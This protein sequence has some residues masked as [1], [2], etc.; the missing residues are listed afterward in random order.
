MVVDG[1]VFG[2]SCSE[3]ERR[4]KVGK[5]DFGCLITFLAI[6]FSRVVIMLA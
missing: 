4:G 1:E 2:L 3:V 5:Y 6:Y